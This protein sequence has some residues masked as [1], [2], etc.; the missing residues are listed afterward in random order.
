MANNDDQKKKGS[1]PPQPPHVSDLILGSLKPRTG[2]DT[3]R[4]IAGLADDK[5]KEAAEV[6][7]RELE[8]SNSGFSQAANE[9]SGARPTVVS[10]MDHL[11]DFFQQIEFDFNRTV[12]GTDY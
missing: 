3:S 2:K 9:K 4:W 8:K 10:F 1:G 5:I 6:A 7:S 12:A 11:F